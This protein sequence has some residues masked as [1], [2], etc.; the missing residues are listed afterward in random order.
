MIRDLITNSAPAG[1]QLTLQLSDPVNEAMQTLRQFL[2]ENVYRSAPVH[3]EFVKAKKIL[4]DLYR[5]LLDNEADLQ[6]ELRSL[7]M[8]GCNNRT[9]PRERL[10][11][12]LLASMTDRYAMSFYKRVFF[13]SSTV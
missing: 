11:C 9:Q 10:V 8:H 1:D 2:Y 13:P 4:S 5:H 3:R 12:D 6:C 7:D